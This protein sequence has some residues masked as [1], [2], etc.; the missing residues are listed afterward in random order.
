[1]EIQKKKDELNN[2]IFTQTLQKNQ[3]SFEEKYHFKRVY[4]HQK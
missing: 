4:N 3:I 1:M 2:N